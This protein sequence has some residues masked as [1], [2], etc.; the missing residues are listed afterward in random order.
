MLRK[1][2]C[3][4]I[5]VLLG[6]IGFSAQSAFSN[7][8]M[9]VETDLQAHSMGCKDQFKGGI[10]LQ[11]SSQIAI[12]GHSNLDRILQRIE[13]RS[14]SQSNIRSAWHED[15]VVYDSACGGPANDRCDSLLKRR[16]CWDGG[17]ICGCYYCRT[18]GY[19]GDSHDN[20]TC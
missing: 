15:N 13:S 1:L 18:C 14:P 20:R 10:C 16:I 9:K 17:D 11:P 8:P 2:M 5:I 6:A 12:P 19:N 3:V 4:S 7:A